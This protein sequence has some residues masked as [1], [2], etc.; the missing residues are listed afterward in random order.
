MR[1]PLLEWP[2]T[3]FR[4]EQREEAE[5]ERADIYSRIYVLL[6]PANRKTLC[7]CSCVVPLKVKQCFT[8][9]LS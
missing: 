9:R 6:C 4:V 7:V 1:V 2:L 5:A 3:S 8:D